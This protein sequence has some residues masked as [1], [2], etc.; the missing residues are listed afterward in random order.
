MLWAVVPLKGE[1]DTIAFPHHSTCSYKHERTEQTLYVFANPMTIVSMAFGHP[2]IVS[3]FGKF[4]LF[5]SV[6]DNDLHKN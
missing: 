4:Y 6:V 1:L 3:S 5:V 2:R